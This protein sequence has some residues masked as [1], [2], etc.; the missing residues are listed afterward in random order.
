MDVAHDPEPLRP[1]LLRRGLCLCAESEAA[2]P[3]AA[4]P[5]CGAGAPSG[6]ELAQLHVRRSEVQAEPHDLHD[7]CLTQ[8]WG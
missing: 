6:G 8:W 2:R 4:S 7:G 1:C 5:R 3:R